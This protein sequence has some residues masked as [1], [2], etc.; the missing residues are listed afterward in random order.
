MFAFFALQTPDHAGGTKVVL[1][2][3][4]SEMP[5]SEGPAEPAAERDLYAEAA[6]RLRHLEASAAKPESG[7]EAPAEEASG[8][9]LK[10]D[11]R[12]SGDPEPQGVGPRGL[13]GSAEAS[14]PED[15]GQGETLPGLPPGTALAG[16]D[17]DKPIFKSLDQ[18]PVVD[19]GSRANRGTASG[20]QPVPGTQLGASA[21]DDPRLAG[22]P[23]GS[24]APLEP[25]AGPGPQADNG[26]QVDGVMASLNVKDQPPEIAAPVVP[27]APPVPLKRP[28]GGPPPAKTVALNG[29]SGTAF[30]T[31][32]VAAPKAARIAILVRGLGRDE[33]IGDDAVS[34]LPT[35]I[36]LGF[37]PFGNSAQQLAGKARERGHEVIVQL[38]LEPADYPVNN[39]GPETLL[40]GSSPDENVTRLGNVLGRFEGY[41]GVTNFL[42]GKILQSKA[43]LRPILENLKSRELIYVGEGKSHAVVRGIAGEIGLRYGGADVMIDSNP[44]PEA[45]KKALD[46]LIAVARKDGSAIGLAYANRVT[47]D[48]LEAW[49]QTLATQGITL[50]PVGVL[51]QTPG[52][53]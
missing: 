32:E 41:S 37:L 24:V 50:V 51:A 48:E 21:P 31:T 17:V 36:S 25:D 34:K 22:L 28:A 23:R 6:E 16:L 8:G 12:L 19:G 1:S 30:S 10:T 45:V 9:D 49:S 13:R 14:L 11:E 20:D 52:A 5:V 4:S 7:A 43:A 38:P 46:R 27:P 40:S 35:A 47:I 53:S 42:G 15:R 26:S 2:I 3:D 29:W 18:Q 39:P 33:R 44:A